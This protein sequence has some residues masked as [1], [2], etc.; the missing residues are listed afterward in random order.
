MTVIVSGDFFL[1]SLMMVY[2][3]N[4][5]RELNTHHWPHQNSLCASFRMDKYFEYFSSA[6]NICKANF[7]NVCCLYPYLLV[8]FLFLACCSWCMFAHDCWWVLACRPREYCETT[9]CF[10]PKNEEIYTQHFICQCVVSGKM[11][12]LQL[13]ITTHKM[14]KDC[15]IMIQKHGSTGGTMSCGQ[16]EEQ[17]TPGRR[18]VYPRLPHVH[19]FLCLLHT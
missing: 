2:R 8:C 14:I 16:I 3:R 9:L 10:S 12:E 5:K 1:L 15:N 6:S 4:G 7:L 13:Q 11:K 19:L 18:S 17:M